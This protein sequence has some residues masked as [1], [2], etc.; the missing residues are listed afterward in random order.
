MIRLYALTMDEIMIEQTLKVKTH[1]DV[2]QPKPKV[3]KVRKL[4]TDIKTLGLG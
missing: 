1:D 4:D 2:S 3:K